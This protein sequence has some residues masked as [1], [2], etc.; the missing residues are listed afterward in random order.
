MLY[1]L[2]AGQ[3][4]DLRRYFG[5]FLATLTPAEMKGVLN[6]ASAELRFDTM[7]AAELP[8]RTAEQLE[9]SVSP[10]RIGRKIGPENIFCARRKCVL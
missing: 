4:R 1:G 5:H 10:A 9:R 7:G 8:R 2:G 3:R 6:R